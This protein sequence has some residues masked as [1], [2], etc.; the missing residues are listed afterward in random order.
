MKRIRV[1]IDVGGT[2]T[3]A[4]AIDNET[5]EISAKAVSPTTHAAKEG[6]AKGIIEVFGLVIQKLEEKFGK[7]FEIIFIAHSTTQ[8]TNALLEGDVAK[9]GIVAMGKGVEGFKAKS[10]TNIQ[11]IEIEGG[12]FMHTHHIFIDISNGVDDNIIQNSI[13]EL[14]EI[15]GCQ[16]IVGAEAFSVDDPQNEKKVLEAAKIMNV[17]ACATHEISGLYGLKVRT[18]TAVVNASILPK[19]META[20]LTEKSIKTAD[21]KSPLMIMRSDGG[22]MT[23]EE[24][25]R[26]PILT[27]LSGPA[28]GI[29]AALMYI[30]A[31][32]AIFLEVGGTSTDIS[33]IRNGRAM[34]KTARIGKHTTYLKTLDSRTLGIAGGSMVEVSGKTIKDVG[35]RSAH[36]ANLA[37]ACFAEPLKLDGKLE[38]VLVRPKEGDPEYL[39]IKNEMGEMFAVTTSCA[40]N[41]LG[42]IKE[43]DYAFGKIDSVKAAFSA[44]AE[45]FGKTPD[46]IAE[47]I[48]QKAYDK[49]IPTIR[50][51]IRDYELKE[52]D[53]L[54]IGG[55]GG[56]FSIVPY[57]AKK[58]DFKYNIANSAEVISAIG[59]ALAMVRET[60]ERNVFSP[61]EEDINKIYRE[62]EESVIKMGANPDS[63]EVFIE[64]EATQNILRAIATGSIEF[65]S[66]DLLRCDIGS[67][68]RLKIACEE[69]RGMGGVKL[70]AQTDSLYVYQGEFIKKALWGL[71][72]NKKK[73]V[74]VMDPKGGVKLNLPGAV[75]YQ[76]TGLSL[77]LELEKIIKENIDYGDAGSS[78]PPV[79]VLYGRRILDFSMVV[80]IDQVLS[81]A[82]I[83]MKKIKDDDNIV[84]LVQK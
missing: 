32:D 33:V 4:V 65:K 21:I 45:Y 73:P 9:V 40:A 16:T 56:A 80:S 69:F 41:F 68:D 1:G 18:R 43:Q 23:I 52:K 74:K 7:D 6:V 39:T 46:A 15:N 79:Y 17:P 28:A 83:E 77:F 59:A 12:K 66:Q 81:V 60:I 57:L 76:A 37:Y 27:L 78:I 29:A 53:I 11:S 47:T 84:V 5:L 36:I 61:T 71:V 31:T 38:I 54:F 55:G 22:V 72:K 58:L 19:M 14:T 26:R 24:M 13:K 48:L 30:R 3:H 2:F 49:I 75:V 62:A 50:D 8:A 70:L 10:D 51:L 82:R 64:I 20:H 34:I 25:H 35:P 42:Y 44:L 63:V 67:E